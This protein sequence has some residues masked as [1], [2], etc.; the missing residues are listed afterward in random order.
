[1]RRAGRRAES[2][3]PV[4]GVGPAG[5]P[6]INDPYRPRRREGD[7]ANGYDVCD[8]RGKFCFRVPT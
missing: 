1:V 2:R 5:R 8:I 4:G 6:L 3:V 7:P